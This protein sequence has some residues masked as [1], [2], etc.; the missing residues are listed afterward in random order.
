MPYGYNV[1]NFG[2]KNL[3]PWRAGANENTTIEFSHDVRVE[4]QP[5]PKGI[6]GLFF[7]INQDNTGEV[8][9][10]KGARSWVVFGM[11]LRMTRCMLKFQLKIILLQK[12]LRMILS[13]CP[14]TLVTG[15]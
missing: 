15:P 5:V 2:Y 7:V 4:G 14:K 11:T 10:S 8:I 12:S 3:A 6:Y 1:Q 13:T 9:L